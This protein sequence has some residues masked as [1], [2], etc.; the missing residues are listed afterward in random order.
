MAD[1]TGMIQAAAGSSGPP[2]PNAWDL[3]YAYYDPSTGGGNIDTFYPSGIW[4]DVRS[5]DNDPKQLYLNAFFVRNSKKMGWIGE[6]GNDAFTSENRYPWNMN[7]INVSQTSKDVTAEESLP[8]GIFFKPDGTRMYVCGAGGDDINEYSLGTA[9]AANTASYVRN[10]DLSANVIAPFNMFWTSDGTSVYFTDNLGDRIV[11]YSVGTAWNVSTLS[12]VQSYSFSFTDPY[13]FCF[14]QDGLSLYVGSAT[15]GSIYKYSLGT[16]WDISTL[17]L[18]DSRT[19]I[20]DFMSGG[21]PDATSTNIQGLVVGPAEGSIYFMLNGGSFFEGV[22]QWTFGG[23]GIQTGGAT[24]EEQPRGLFFKPDGTKMYVAGQTGNSVYEYT[25]STPWEIG[26]ASY[27]Q[28]FGIGVDPD[29]LFFKSDG[30]K[31]YV[32]DDSANTI[33]EYSLGTAW[34]VSTSTFVTTFSVAGQTTTPDDMF[35]DDSGTRMYVC[36]NSDET[37][38]QYTLGTAWSV[39]TASYVR[40]LTVA[41]KDPQ[42]IFFKEDGLIMYIANAQTATIE[43]YSLSSAWNISTASALSSYMVYPIGNE[44][45]LYS[46]RFRPNGEQFFVIDKGGLTYGA[47]PTVYANSFFR[48]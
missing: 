36:S 16:A 42:G 24:G 41:S 6:E 44:S 40:T 18:V 15:R 43:S 27:S 26:T 48:E 19:F 1:L 20:F 32:V 7:D 35:I 14:S 3:D 39:A 8:R 13:G 38:D 28:L 12:Y 23:F 4:K 2:N 17:S 45:N 10:Y 37:V 11:Q 34:D 31:M 29:G 30:T 25:L 22:A 5:T 33:R 9:F 46:I 21:F 47:P